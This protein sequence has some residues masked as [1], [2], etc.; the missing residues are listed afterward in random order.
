MLLQLGV[1]IAVTEYP[2]FSVLLGALSRNV[3]VTELNLDTL[4]VRL[5]HVAFQNFLTRTQT[6]QRLQI[7]SLWQFGRLYEM[8]QAAVVSAFASNT[9]LCEL[10]LIGWQRDDLAP[11]L[12]A[13]QDHPKLLKIHFRPERTGFVPSLSGLEVLLHSQDS[14]VKELVF[15]RVETSTVGL[16]T[17][18]QELG[19]NTTLTNLTIW[20][21]IVSGENVQQLTSM[22]R[23]NTALTS[24]VLAS[25]SLGSPGVVEIASA[26]YRNTSVKVLDLADN[27]SHDI[28]SANVLRDLMR[29]NKTITNLTLDM[30][31]FGN[32][33]AAVR[34]LAKGVGSN[35]TLQHLGLGSC[36]LGDQ[37]I[38]V[39]ANGLGLRDSGL[40]ELNLYDNYITSVG[41]RALVDNFT[42]ASNGVAKLS[43][44]RNRIGSEGA[45]TLADALGRNAMSSLKHLELD[46]CGIDDDGFVALVSALERN[47]SLQL[48]SLEENEIGEQDFLAL[49]ESLPNIKGLQRIDFTANET[50]ASTLPLLLEGFRKNTSLVEV[51][52]GGYEKG[53]WSQEMK[54]L[55]QRNRFTPLLKAS[56]P[57]ETSPRLGIW[58]RALGKVAIEPDVLFYVLRSNPKLVGSAG[59]SKKRKRDGDDD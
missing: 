53:E 2:A 19:R 1:D 39:L 25:N 7:S 11:V 23:R 18:M 26:L 36:G 46:A 37:G 48:L 49:A 21:S 14:K 51:N 13:L 31:A 32:N 56:D 57:P 42:K 12:T 41:V 58:S 55:G 30:N 5:A 34:I 29:H 44:S 17:V 40:V 52:I 28:E 35:T 9:T 4:D 47:E 24:L 6:L 50:F 16:Q 20:G 10:K 59:G 45:A 27:G 3:S 15:D 38:S 43:L 33:A 54:F 8:E 22:L